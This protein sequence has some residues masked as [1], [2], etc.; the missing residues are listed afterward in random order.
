ME[1]ISV[2]GIG[3]LG[4]CLALNLEDSGFDVMGC[5][6]SQDYVNK[7]N[8]KK[9]F[10]YEPGVNE[11]LA[12]SKS[13]R[14]TTSMAETI[15]HSQVIFIMVATPS[16]ENGKYDCTQ[17]ENVINELE[18]IGKQDVRKLFIVGC[19]TFPGYCETIVERLD[20]LNYDVLYNPEFIAQG[21]IIHGQLYP[22]MVLIGETTE[23]NGKKLESIHHKICKNNPVYSRMSLTE[24][25]LTKLSINCFITTKISFANMIGDVCNKLGISH[26]RVLE[27]I[28]KDSRIGNKYLKWGFGFGGPCFPRDNKALAVLCKEV[29][30]NPSV[31]IASEEYNKLHLDYQVEHILGTTE[32]DTIY[33]DHISYKKGSNLIVESQQLQVALKLVEAGKKVV[34]ED[35][36]VVIEMVRKLYGDT[37]EYRTKQ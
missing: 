35:D 28:G 36:E 30:I 7:L 18:K 2:I 20:I 13:F 6:V 16:L 10:S 23:E 34:V 21:N 12:K 26:E 19:T 29:G 17:V 3:K 33:M 1:K 8:E 9:F 24:A 27:S 31:S 5:D 11:L 25:E 4:L 14:A 15:K 22:D 37:F 32:S